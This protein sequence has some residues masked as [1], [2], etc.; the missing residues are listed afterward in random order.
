MAPADG[1]SRLSVVDVVLAATAMVCT[2]G[3]AIFLFSI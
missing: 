2:V 3:A 1:G